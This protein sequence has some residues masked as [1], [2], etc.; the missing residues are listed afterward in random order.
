MQSFDVAAP[1]RYFPDARYI[2][3][4][5]LHGR[6]FNLNIAVNRDK[7]K[8][9]RLRKAMD[10]LSEKYGVKLV[11]QDGLAQFDIGESTVHVFANRPDW[12]G[13]FY[14]VRSAFDWAESEDERR[15]SAL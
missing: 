6:F 7:P 15:W 5:C 10:I 1:E 14:T 8:D 2:Q 12:F 11:L 3:F 4:A 9:D 13:V